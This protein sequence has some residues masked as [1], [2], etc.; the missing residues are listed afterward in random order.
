MRGRPPRRA[1][2]MRAWQHLPTSLTNGQP[3]VIGMEELVKWDRA[4]IQTEG[5]LWRES[6]SIGQGFP[7]SADLPSIAPAYQGRRPRRLPLADHGHVEVSDRI[8]GRF[9]HP[10]GPEKSRI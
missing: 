10:R 8:T 1:G 7:D 5:P 2:T 9:V 3:I 6:G 4:R